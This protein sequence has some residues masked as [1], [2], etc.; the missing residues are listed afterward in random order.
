MIVV[1][2]KNY[3]SGT[4]ALKLAKK[5]EKSNKK[6]IVAVPTLDL[7]E[8]AKKTKLRVF[9]Q[10]V[11]TIGDRATG[12]V[13]LGA[14]KKSGAVGTLINHSEHKVNPKDFDFILGSLKKSNTKVIA[15]A[16]SIKEARILSKYN[17]WAIAFEDPKLIGTGKS[18]TKYNPQTIKNFVKALSNTKIIPLCGAGISNFN[19]YKK[20]KELG[21]RGVLISSAIANSRNTGKFLGDLKNERN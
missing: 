17:P 9:A 3:V 19:D 20:A 18:V 11:D 13:T 1:N 14:L 7:K 16:S 15:C 2:F 12:F 21:C 5:I 8:I 4:K 10:H 6:I